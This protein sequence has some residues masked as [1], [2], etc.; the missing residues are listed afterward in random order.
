MEKEKTESTVKEVELSA[1]D[2]N[3]NL[4]FIQQ[5]KGSCSS[6]VVPGWDGWD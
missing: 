4:D 3:I 2:V 5:A 6:F 1:N